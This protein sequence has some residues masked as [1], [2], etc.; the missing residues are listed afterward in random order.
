MSEIA[1]NDWVVW[2]NRILDSMLQGVPPGAENQVR[3]KFFC[4]P[5]VNIVLGKFF[6]IFL[7]SFSIFIIPD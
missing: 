7:H 3:V 2:K 1:Q 5:W 4:V 6:Q